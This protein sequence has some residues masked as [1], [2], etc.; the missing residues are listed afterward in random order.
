MLMAINN[1]INHIIVIAVEASKDMRKE[2]FRIEYRVPSLL[3]LFIII[4]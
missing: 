3:T 1:S 2:L 4:L